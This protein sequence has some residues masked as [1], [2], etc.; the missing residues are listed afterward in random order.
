MHSFL[1]GTLNI[2]IQAYHAILFI[3]RLLLTLSDLVLTTFEGG[4]FRSI[5]ITCMFLG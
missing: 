5:L 2:K 4:A 1:Q 3:N